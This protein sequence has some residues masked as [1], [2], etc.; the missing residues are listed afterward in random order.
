MDLS[1]LHL[2]FAGFMSGPNKCNQTQRQV[3]YL[4]YE[5]LIGHGQVKTL[6]GESGSN[7]CIPSAHSKE[8]SAGFCRISGVEQ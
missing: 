6:S 1:V 4:E 5:V 8:E 3:E 2:R 7:S